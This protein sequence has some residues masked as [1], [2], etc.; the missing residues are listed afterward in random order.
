MNKSAI[1]ISDNKSAIKTSDKSKKRIE[2]IINYLEINGESTANEIA[3]TIG[4]KAPRTRQLL[5]NMEMVEK[6]GENKNRK[7]RLKNQEYKC[8]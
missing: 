4:L 7:Y 5:N 3:E 1:K 8:K 6:T 2:N